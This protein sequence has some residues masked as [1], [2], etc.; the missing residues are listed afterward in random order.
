MIQ[1][2]LTDKEH[3]RMISL[4]ESRLK[5]LPYRIQQRKE[6]HS[7]TFHKFV[8]FESKDEKEAIDDNQNRIYNM[9][10][11]V[12]LYKSILNKLNKK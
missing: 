7:E 12:I 10:A 6:R 2:N 11:N 3:K 8:S 4:I 1:V 5:T 9:E